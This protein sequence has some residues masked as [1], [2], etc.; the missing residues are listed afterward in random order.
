MHGGILVLALAA[1]VSGARGIDAPVRGITISTHRGGQDWGSDRMPEA[2]AAIRTLG[3]N[4]VA[5]HPYARVG[6]DGSVRTR[7]SGATA[8]VHITRPIREAQS[9]GLKILIK[10]HLS[11]W[12]SPFGWR[13]EIGFEND[14][15]WERFWRDYENVHPSDC[16]LDAKR[17]RSR[18]RHRAP[19][20][21]RSRK[22]A[23]G[24]SSKTCARKPMCL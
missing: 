6:G 18:R 10:P 15:A 13:G 11:Y 22:R 4:W 9:A 12:G 3:A 23:G 16:A 17:R 14:E 19:S 1:T 24:R 20:N 7:Y 2:L 21:R 8:P 5:I